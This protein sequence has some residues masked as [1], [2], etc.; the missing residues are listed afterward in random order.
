MF[1][2]LDGVI[3]G[4]L[5]VTDGFAVGVSN[6]GSPAAALAAACICW[7]RFREAS[8]EWSTMVE[9]SFP[10]ICEKSF[11]F[12]LPTVAGAGTAT[13]TATAG[14]VAVTGAGA[15]VCCGF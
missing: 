13:A 4:G 7:A 10:F 3:G 2:P 14:A 12:V 8:D 6:G 9:K 1:D 15:V 11:P 5:M